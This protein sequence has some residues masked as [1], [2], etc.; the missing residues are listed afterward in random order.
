[1]TWS[2]LP[3]IASSPIS[4]WKTVLRQLAFGAVAFTI[5]WL[6]G[7]HTLAIVVL[8]V[9]GSMAI[10]SALSAR[11]AH[12][13]NRAIFWVASTVGRVL[14]FVML[15]LLEFLVFTPVAAFL[16][17]VR[18]DPLALGSSPN[19]ASLWRPHFAEGRKPLYRRQFTY[20]VPRRAAGHR[21]ALGRVALVVGAVVLLVLVDLGVGTGLHAITSSDPQSARS[22][23]SYY[24]KVAAVPKTPWWPSVLLGSFDQ[25]YGEQFE[26]MREFEGPSYFAT[27]YFNI[28]NGVRLSYEPPVSGTQKPVEVLFLGGSTM[29]GAFQ[30]DDY[31]IASDIA[32]LAGA[33]GIPIHVVNRGQYAYAV[34]QEVELLEELL[35]N[36]YRPDVVVFYDGVNELGIQSTEGTT[37]IPSTLKAEQYAQA[38]H[39]YLN[40]GASQPLANRI[41]DA[42]VNRSAVALAARDIG[43]LFSSAPASTSKLTP[44]QGTTTAPDQSLAVERANDAVQIYLRA[45][46]LIQ[47]LAAAYGFHALTF[48][49]PFLY[50]KKP[51]AAEKNIEGSEGENPTAEFA[52][53]AQAR[54]DL[55]PPVIDLSDALNGVTA[56]VMID[57]EHTNELGALAVAKAMYPH[58]KPVLQS[59]SNERRP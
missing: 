53:A 11:V 8:V 5:L 16:W 20:E 52:M 2:E 33:N 18:R 37:T 21:S 51:V 25:A 59:V 41:Y 24:S 34:W 39:Q 4:P 14:S 46:H 13:M 7:R 3:R 56:P 58:L 19:D 31:T 49:Q 22:L 47:R 42:Y 15:G 6:L 26:P 48:W 55:R 50:S 12:V 10:L 43:S 38:V 57:Y 54:K 40:P 29:E 32:R 30:R 23:T 35:T 45:V 44:Q 36:G 9:A 28:S 17:L 27:P 1:V